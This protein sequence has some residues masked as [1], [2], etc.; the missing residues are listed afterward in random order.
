M[1][2]SRSLIFCHFLFLTLWAVCEP[3]HP[4]AVNI[5]IDI[6]VSSLYI[7]CDLPMGHQNYILNALHRSTWIFNKLL[8]I[9][10]FNT[11]DIKY[12][13]SFR[14]TNTFNKRWFFFSSS[15]VFLLHILRLTWFQNHLRF[16]TVAQYLNFSGEK[17]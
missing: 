10:F 5:G 4:E 9:L 12:Y 15:Q 17:K 11:V 2:E 13:F 6:V 14:S 16:F 8:F 1:F 7:D 3:F